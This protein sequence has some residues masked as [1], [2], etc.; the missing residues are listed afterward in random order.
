MDG[1]QMDAVASGGL[2]VWGRL[3]V[4]GEM[5]WI[6]CVTVVRSRGVPHMIS[7]NCSKYMWQASI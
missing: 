5:L 2:S 7:N 3:E 1:D 6:G 4:V